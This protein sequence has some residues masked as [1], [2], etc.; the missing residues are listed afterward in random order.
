MIT[1]TWN[2]GGLRVLRG[3]KYFTAYWV[4]LLELQDHYLDVVECGREF[5][6]GI[7]IWKLQFLQ[8]MLQNRKEEAWELSQNQFY[9]GEIE[10]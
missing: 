3:D 9:E 7:Y 8:I 2:T 1:F 6:A 5:A 10:F 4:E